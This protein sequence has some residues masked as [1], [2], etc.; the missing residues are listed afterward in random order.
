MDGSPHV[1]EPDRRFVRGSLYTSSF[2]HPFPRL[3]PSPRLRS[4]MESR[5]DSGRN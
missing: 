4:L 1:T 5:H 2:P 3:A